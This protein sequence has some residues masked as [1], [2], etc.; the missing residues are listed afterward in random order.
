M[1]TLATIIKDKG[2]ELDKFC[3][4][5]GGFKARHRR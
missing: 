1:D 4:S 5:D 3:P 2:D